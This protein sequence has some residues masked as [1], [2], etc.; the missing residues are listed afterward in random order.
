MDRTSNISSGECS[1][2][3]RV[4]GCEWRS[5]EFALW[6]W[7]VGTCRTR[8]AVAGPWVALFPVCLIEV[9]DINNNTTLSWKI[10]LAESCQT[11]LGNWCSNTLRPRQNGCQFADN[12]SKL[13]FFSG[14][15]YVCIY[16]Q[17]SLKFVPGDAINNKP[18]LVQIMTLC[19]IDDKTLS[20][21]MMV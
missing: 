6:P 16:I 14:N 7:P 3:S 21:A 17:I 18:T 5:R 1:C 11:A 13:I 12:I 20:E 15:C 9:C 8:L 10:P 4:A 19:W 2:V